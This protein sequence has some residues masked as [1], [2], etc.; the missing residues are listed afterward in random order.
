MPLA[1]IIA[2]LLALAA[3]FT[4]AACGDDEAGEVEVEDGQVEDD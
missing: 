3:P 1:R 2:L 4:L